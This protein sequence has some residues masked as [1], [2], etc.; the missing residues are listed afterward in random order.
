MYD[1][2]RRRSAE[3][4]KEGRE[5]GAFKT[6]THT[7]ESGGNYSQKY[8]SEGFHVPDP[9]LAQGSTYIIPVIEPGHRG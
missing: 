4:R 1:L 5:D 9:T 7:S 6:G 8:A 2:K 3:G